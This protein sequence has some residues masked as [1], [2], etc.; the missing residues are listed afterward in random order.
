M[1][2]YIYEVNDLDL[3]QDNLL[4]AETLFHSANG[5]LG[6]RSNFEEGYPEGSKSIRGTYING[7]YDFSQMNQAEKLH[8]LIE[9]KQTM[10][11]VVDTQGI[12]LYVDGEKFTMFSGKVL[13][14]SRVLDMGRGITIRHIVWENSLGK[15]VRIDITRMASFAYQQL[16][17]VKYEVTPLNF[18]GTV[19]IKSFHEGQVSN[20]FDPSDPRVAGEASQYLH[21]E[22]VAVEDGSSVITAKTSKSQISICSIVKNITDT[23]PQD[24]EKN[25]SS[26]TETF[27]LDVA[28]G[29]T[30]RFYKYTILADSAHYDDSGK[31][32]RDCLKEVLGMPADR[33]Y[34]LQE[35]YLTKYWDNC[36]L[37]VYGD[38]E[39]QKAIRYNQYQLIQSASKDSKGNIA[40]KGLSGE[41]YEGHYFWDTE[42]YMQPFFI[43]NERE[44]AKNLIRYRYGTLEH[45]KENARELGHAKGAL[46]PWRTIMGKEC[47][48]YFPSGT[49][50]YHINGDIAYSIISYY[51]ATKDLDFMEECGAEILVETARLWMDLG[52]YHQGSF[53]LNVVTG[54]DEY[55][56][57][58]NNNYYT[59]VLAQYNLNWAVKIYHILEENKKAGALKEKLHIT[60][61]ELEEFSKA[62][63]AMCLLYDKELGINP[64]DDSFLQKK[65]WDLK[66]TP[67]ESF[68]LLMNYHPLTLYRYQVCKQADT[69]MA[70]FI[71]EDA[72][73]LETMKKSYDYYEK[74]TTH[75][76]S[77]STCIFSIMAARFG[78]AG[79]AYSYFGESAKLD[80]FNTHKNTK[81]GI[82]TAN[83]GG[84]YM[85]MVY[86]FGGLRI[87]E[88]GLYLRPLLPDEWEG[89]QFRIL[90][91]DSKLLVEVRGESCVIKLLAGTSKKI[92]VHDVPYEITD[93]TV[94]PLKKKGEM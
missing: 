25:E 62:A 12:V 36:A 32:A 91:E 63:D 23:K 76:S 37:E 4:L 54:P 31:A 67:A 34:E 75:D 51:L 26:V 6:V 39:L 59:N 83:M 89:Y 87:K 74:I 68:P 9:E 70:H 19:E 61:G 80:L 17:L 29:K 69:V 90:Y 27:S 56:C 3:S 57:M 18:S 10:L 46:Y 60:A 50:A 65:V 22:K 40:A 88:S 38:E 14:K 35:D 77:L 81:D 28:E 92:V 86:G 49:A 66:G 5:Y 15:Q 64:Q 53:N 94:I 43:L 79:K 55:T 93:E 33:L 41:G 84:T 24:I 78:D 13:E 45:A 82:H 48:G 2:Q 44:V 85:A 71:L 58:V 16:F 30:S 42:M 1:N 72:Q 20:Y 8:G 7:V 47:S 21:L 52:C 73:D 11:N